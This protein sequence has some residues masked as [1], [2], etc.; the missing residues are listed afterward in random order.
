MP[1]KV[2]KELKKTHSAGFSPSTLQA[3]QVE[4]LVALGLTPKDIAAALL[5][6]LPLLK[7]YYRR[8][9]EIGATLVNAKVGHVALQM[10]LDGQNPNM[11]MF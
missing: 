10:A 9:L 11:T 4:S 1:Q 3:R 7:F 8:E 6:E 2:K 5:I